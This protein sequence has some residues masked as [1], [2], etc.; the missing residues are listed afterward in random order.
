VEDKLVL[1]NPGPVNLTSRVRNALT[2]PD[3]CHREPEFS[4]LQGH[5]RSALINV[6]ELSKEEYGSVLLT[7]SGTLAVESMITS[8]IPRHGK[9]LVL[10]NGVYGERIQKMAQAHGIN[11]AVVAHQWGKELDMARIEAQ[12]ADD[13]EV[14]H[15]A[16]VHHETTTG[17]LNDLKGSQSDRN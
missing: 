7:G 12:L 13:G 9:L 14:S 6:Y 4:R 16:V 5:I 8:L 10:A 11:H 1:L 3:L 17:C 2:K 15:V